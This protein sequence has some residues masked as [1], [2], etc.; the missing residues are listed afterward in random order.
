MTSAEFVYTVLLRPKAL[1]RLANKI[2]RMILPAELKR[3]GA[4]IVLNPHDPVISG[5]LT[6][7]VYEKSETEFFCALCRPGMTFLDI[8]ANVGY[9][10]ALAIGRVGE[11]G[12]IIALEPDKENFQYLQRTVAANR[13]SNVT[14]IQKAAADRNGFLTLYVSSENRGDNRLYANELSDGSYSVE[15]STIDSILDDQGVSSV[16]LIKMDVQGFE[17]QVLR[18]MRETIRRSQGLIMLTEFWPYGLTR[19]GSQPS[20]VLRDLES[21]GMALY[22]LHSSGKVEKIDDHAAFI[23]RYDGRKYA[24]LLGVAEAAPRDW[25]KLG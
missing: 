8:G 10:T 14:C 1:K 4:T 25:M 9:Y 16:D 22:E 3:H 17:G 5:A 23:S 24:S 15:V 21:A 7:G 11:A 2:I 18:G 6:F 19:A 13:G 20:E 12:K